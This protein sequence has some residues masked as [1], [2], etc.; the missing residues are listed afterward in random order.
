[1]GGG[2]RAPSPSD[3]D[4]EQV[5]LEGRKGDRGRQERGRRGNITPPPSPSPRPLLFLLPPPPPALSPCFPAHLPALPAPLRPRGRPRCRGGGGGGGR[6]GALTSPSPPLSCLPLRAPPAHRAPP[7][8]PC[9]PPPIT[10]LRPSDPS[11]AQPSSASPPRSPPAARLLTRSLPA[12]LAPSASRDVPAAGDERRASPR[13]RRPR[14]VPRRRDPGGAALRSRR[15]RDA[16][17][18]AS[19]GGKQGPALR[20]RGWRG[21]CALGSLCSPESHLGVPRKVRGCAQKK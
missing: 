15:S 16:G 21:F 4:L 8:W 11:A 10:A 7:S 5:C 13:P 19:A 20:G 1:M 18:G 12:P 2:G 14:G 3:S 17:G 9:L 6:P